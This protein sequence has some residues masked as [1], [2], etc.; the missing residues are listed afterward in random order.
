MA[1][2]DFDLRLVIGLPI[3]DCRLRIGG[4]RSTI[5]KSSMAC[6][7]CDDTGWKAE[8]ANGVRRVVRCDC[9]L[10]KGAAFRV[11]RANIP[12]RYQHCT[13]GNFRAY[14]ESLT[15]GLNFA[16]R[17]INEFPLD[18]GLLLIGLPGVGKT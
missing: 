1:I 9:W 4:C 16:H 7:Q 5:G 3:A 8:T 14:N 2:G 17:V 15:R 12:K 13:F 11:E 6:D 10:R 18:R